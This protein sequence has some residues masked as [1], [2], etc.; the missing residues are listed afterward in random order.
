MHLCTFQVP[1][2]VD[3][4]DIG[5]EKHAK[6]AGLIINQYMSEIANFLSLLYKKKGH[7]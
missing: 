6:E 4:T 1:N 7:Q 3:I 2:G 5:E